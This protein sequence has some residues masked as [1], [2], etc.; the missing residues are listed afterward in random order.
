M[1]N[2]ITLEFMMFIQ[3]DIENYYADCVAKSAL[4]MS[5]TNPL[6]GG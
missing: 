5:V 1:F 3:W 2:I 6:H 4:A